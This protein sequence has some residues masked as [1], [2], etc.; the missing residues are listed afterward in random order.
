MSVF[1]CRKCFPI[2]VPD[3][4]TDEKKAEV[5][6]LTRKTS[7][8]FAIQYFRPIGMDLRQAK[9]IALHVTRKKGVCHGCTTELI[10]YEGQCP[11]CKRLNLDW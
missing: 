9:G 10:E 6:S 3:D 5:A 7:P 1:E 8:I 11:K 4:W 2:D